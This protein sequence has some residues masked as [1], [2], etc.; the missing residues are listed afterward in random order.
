MPLNDEHIM[1][2]P[3]DNKIEVNVLVV[4]CV[5][6]LFFKLCQMPGVEDGIQGRKYDA[7]LGRHDDEREGWCSE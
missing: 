5:L 7:C 4:V 1:N 6:F 3:S 2:N